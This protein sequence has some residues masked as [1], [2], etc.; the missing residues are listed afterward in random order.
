MKNT[1][2]LTFCPKCKSIQTS[3]IIWIKF[4]RKT[5]VIELSS[6]CLNCEEEHVTLDDASDLSPKSS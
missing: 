3:D 2:I 5:G 1:G 4:Y 6:I